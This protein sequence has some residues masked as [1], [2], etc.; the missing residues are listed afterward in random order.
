MNLKSLRAKIAL[1]LNENVPGH[2]WTTWT[3]NQV[4]GYILDALLILF[5]ERPELFVHQQI[6]EVAA[7]NPQDICNCTRIERVFGECNEQGTILRPLRKR[8]HSD[9]LVW[10]GA[11]CKQ[12]PRYFHLREYALEENGTQLW[13]FP[14]PPAGLSVNV[15]V[16]CLV[17]PDKLTADS[18]LDNELVPAII[19]WVLFRAK[20]MDGENNPAIAQIASA[21]Q[22]TFWTLVN[23]QR[24][25]GRPTGA[26][27]VPQNTSQ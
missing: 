14:H 8:S 22:T 26:R 16:E 19:Q 18:E 13:V 9:K 7:S 17:L 12:D 21:H 3:E 24:R 4:D 5:Q 1:D 10:P 2:E 11:S 20:M 15:L 6:L 27:S 25:G 23:D